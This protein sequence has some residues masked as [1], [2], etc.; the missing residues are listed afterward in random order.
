MSDVDR[1]LEQIPTVFKR[2]GPL[3]DTHDVVHRLVEH[4]QQAYLSAML[5]IGGEEPLEVLHERID[6]YLAREYA[7]RVR[8]HDTQYAS[9]DAFGEITMC[10]RWKKRRG[11]PR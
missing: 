9:P 10:T 6:D 7:D 1:L 3:F 2:L 8:V 5:E 4:D 11:G